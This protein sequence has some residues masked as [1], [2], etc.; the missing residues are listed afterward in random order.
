MAAL[1]GVSAGACS[2]DDQAKL[3]DPNVIGKKA[4]DCGKTAY[5]IITGNFNHAKFDSCLTASAGISSACAECY[6]VSGEYGA[7]NCKADC[8]LGWCKSGC[9]NCVKP[10][11]SSLDQCT[12][13]TS[14]AATPCLSENST[15]GTLKL[16]WSDCGDASTHGKATSLTPESLT[17][18][19]K[20]TVTGQGSLDEAVTGG[21]FELDMHASIIS[22]KFTGDICT[23]KTF[24]LPLG[25]GTL[26]WDGMKC[27]LAAGTL[28]V[29]TDIMLSSAIP[30][31]YAKATIS[32]KATTTQGDK[33]LCLSLN[34]APAFETRDYDKEWTAFKEKFNKVYDDLD[35]EAYRFE[36]FKENL[37][38]IEETN[39]KK[40][41]YLLGVNEFSD[42]PADEFSAK[43]F[44]F[45]P[46][47][48]PAELSVHEY[49]GEV[50]ASS[51]DWR[52]SGAVTPVK[53]QGQCGSCWSFSTTGALEGAWKISQGQLVSLSEEEFVQCDTGSNGCGG[54]S[55]QQAFDWAKTQSLCT[56][57]SYPYTSG[58][59]TGGSCHQ[60]GCSVG[61]P[62][63]GVTGYRSVGQTEQALMSALNQQ[64]VSIAVEADKSTFQSYSSGIMTGNCG[65]NLDHG[66]L[67]VGYGTEAGNDYWIVKNSWGTVWGEQG[68]GR[69]LRGKNSAG[70]CGILMQASYPQ[71]SGAPGPA[72]GPSPGPSPPAPGPGPAPGSTH[73]EKP[74]CRSDEIEVQIQGLTGVTCSPKC[75]GTS[76]PSDVPQGTTATPQCALQDATSGDKYCALTCLLGGCP[77]GAK[78]RHSGLMGIC[79]Y[80]DAARNPITVTIPA[81]IINV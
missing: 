19:Q 7:K 22:K 17:L 10:S 26:S 23:A 70:E 20:T 72:P 31:Q 27:P 54:G 79:M 13:F 60:T 39:A 65:T 5:N 11:Q 57:A 2:A 45:K 81:S 12:G 64:P 44:G 46:V 49:R 48:A 40:L 35:A 51:V 69:L 71:V 37:D 33:L 68:F 75:D 58:G 66:I 80:D 15:G 42:M 41:T 24:T 61:I 36:V 77:S 53:N 67:A 29:S 30:S 74:P 47:D 1:S 73:Y 9:L 25:L 34:T 52:T 50:L 28:S 56:E 21:T 4:G 18:G 59:G 32:M 38:Y 55:M 3:A 16:T 63:G 6:A 43:M 62:Q 76:C 78:C 14:G 8:L